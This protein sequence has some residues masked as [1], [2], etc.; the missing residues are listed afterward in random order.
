[1][2]TILNIE[3]IILCMAVFC[4][5]TVPLKT[6][7]AQGNQIDM[8]NKDIKSETAT[9][10]GGC[11]WCVEKDFEMLEGVFSVISG[12]AGGNT[13]NPTYE[14]VCRGNTGHLEVVQVHFDA[15]K[16]DYGTLVDYFFKH[17]D[18]TDPGGQFVDRGNQYR[19]AIFYHDGEQAKIAL[20]KKKALE[21]S[22]KFDKPVVTEIL[23]LMAFYPAEAYH[24]DYYKKEP[25]R[26][27]TYRRGSGRDLFLE[28]T[29]GKEAQTPKKT[30]KGAAYHKP[31]DGELREKLTPL[32]YRVTQNE[33]TEPPFKNDYWD[34]HEPGIYVDIV[35]GEPLFSSLDKFD[36]R[37][38]WPSFIRP[39]ETDNIVEKSDR[40]LFMVRTEVRSRHGDSHLGHVFDDGP[41][42]TGLRYCI[43]SAIIV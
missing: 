6:H 8:D 22:G 42:P 40:T 5:G 23:P 18:P 27:A 13:E 12:Y 17:V 21:A 33:G 10:A 29:W 30:I 39:L 41:P 1:M 9:F 36:S 38:G 43:N 16:L 4:V 28:R 26:Y 7:A 31:S 24:Q 25:L 11:F 35:S 32:Q 14:A 15:R 2:R 3:A 34:N 19:S 37:T 20:A